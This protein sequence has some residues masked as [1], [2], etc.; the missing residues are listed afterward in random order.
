MYDE[1]LTTLDN[2]FA[3]VHYLDSIF[4]NKAKLEEF[5]RFSEYEINSKVL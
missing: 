1:I 5:K 2:N 4:L 3:L